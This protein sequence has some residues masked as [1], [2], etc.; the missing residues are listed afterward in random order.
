MANSLS[1]THTDNDSLTTGS[2]EYEALTGAGSPGVV[3]VS[4]GDT[5]VD[6][7]AVTTPYMAIVTNH[8]TEKTVE[9][10]V[11][12]GG[13]FVSFMTLAPLES[14][15]VRLNASADYL[16]KKQDGSAGTVRVSFEAYTV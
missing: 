15:P 2:V 9:V 6:L 3:I 7:S 4:S 16:L 12:S 11:E 8:D 14:M 10:G 13:A 1:W 5:P